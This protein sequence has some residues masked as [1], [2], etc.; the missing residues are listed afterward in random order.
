MHAVLLSCKRARRQMLA[1][2]PAKPKC[3][4]SHIQSDDQ[5]ETTARLMPTNPSLILPGTSRGF[6]GAYPQGKQRS[7]PPVPP[8]R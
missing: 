1:E 5:R 7:V 3:T 8:K 4:E 2:M 6:A